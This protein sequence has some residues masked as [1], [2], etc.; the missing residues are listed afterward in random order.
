MVMNVAILR[1]LSISVSHPMEMS[2]LQVV[3]PIKGHGWDLQ[4]LKLASLWEVSVDHLAS[5]AVNG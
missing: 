5:T 2:D 1:I 3:F 4:S